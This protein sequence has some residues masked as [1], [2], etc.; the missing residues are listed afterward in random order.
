MSDLVN[1]LADQVVE[2]RDSGQVFSLTVEDGDTPERRQAVIDCHGAV[3]DE[4]RRRGYQVR[5][6]VTRDEPGREHI[7]IA[8]L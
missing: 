8:I 3:L 7:A 2:L 5:A 6:T 1:D 4:L